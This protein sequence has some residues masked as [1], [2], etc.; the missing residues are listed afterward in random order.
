MQEQLESS[1]RH[2]NILGD[3]LMV[4]L[5]G[6]WSKDA[7]PATHQRLEL[8]AGVKEVSSWAVQGRTESWSNSCLVSRRYGD[9]AA[10]PSWV[11][12]LGSPH[13]EMFPNKQT[14]TQL[15]FNDRSATQYPNSVCSLLVRVS[16]GSARDT[17]RRDLD[18]GRRDRAATKKRWLGGAVYIVEASKKP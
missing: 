7:F 9:A 15:C 13:K 16:S 6:R 4:M 10:D 2:G 18:S 8:G 1:L 11:R 17:P 5:P 12:R 14:S 3:A